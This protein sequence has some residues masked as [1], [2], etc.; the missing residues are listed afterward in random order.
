MN[1]NCQ[2]DIYS[3]STNWF[4]RSRALLQ[5]CSTPWG[6]RASLGDH[7]NYGRIFTRDAVMSGLAGLFIQDDCIVDGLI[8]TLLSLKK[9]QGKQGQ[10]PSNFLVENDEI[11][12]VSFGT[13]SPK[14]D[15]C[16]WYL[17]A[18]GLL[19]KNDKI[20]KSD[21][22]Q[23]VEATINLLDGIEFNGKHLV[24]IPKGGN[25]ADEYIYEGYILYDQV[26]RAWGLSLL[27]KVYK[28]DAWIKK[29]DHI[30]QAIQKNY[31]DSDLSHFVSSTYPGGKLEQFD[32]PAHALLGLLCSTDNKEISLAFDWINDIFLSKE[33]LPPAFYPVIEKGHPLWETLKNYHLYRFKNTPHHFH[34]GGIWWIW[35][36]WLALALKKQERYDL[37]S[38]LTDTA[39][40]YLNDHAAS[41][42]FD[43][44]ISGDTL[45]LNGTKQLG[46]TATGIIFMQLASQGFD[47]S[48]LFENQ[49]MCEPLPIKQEYFALSEEVISHLS[50]LSHL[51]QNKLVIGIAGES[52]SGKSTTASCLKIA[53]EKH[54]I[55]AIILHQDGYFKLPPKENH[56]KRKLNIDH[57]GPEEVDLERMQAHINAFKESAD[58]IDFRTVNYLENRF[59]THRTATNGATVLIVEGVYTFDLDKLDYKLFMSRS[60]HDTLE[61]RRQRSR[62][63]YDPFVEE[64]LEVEHQIVAPQR[65][66]ADAVV[67]INYRL[68]ANE[69]VKK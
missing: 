54:G 52:G 35:L 3:D 53:L 9:L 7:E 34:N 44:Y 46:F 24:Y 41:F 37:L 33:K 48:A 29:S 50:N 22:H 64:V 56:Q 23:S 31:V 28:Q 47:T 30:L 61:K 32:L 51:E 2:R 68:V 38:S 20:N 39:F 36:G 25:W 6:I 63:T 42:Q 5:A 49:E 15:S 55:K 19:I 1:T 21:F 45:V 65:S 13:L 27:G 60:Y 17:I 26:L 66:L 67:D 16:T 58:Y 12:K 57:V 8:N 59:G 69:V 10:I 40:A 4:E 62:E 14:I 18:V 43:E 11:T